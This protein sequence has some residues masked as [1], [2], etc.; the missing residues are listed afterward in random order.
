MT[1][2]E[3]LDLFRKE[4]DDLSKPYLWSDEEFYYYLNEAQNLHVRL[5]GGIADRR[6]PMTKLTYK[7]GDQFKKYDERILRIKGAFDESNKIMTVMNLDNF[8]SVYLEDDYGQ[9]RNVGLEDDRTGNIE[10]LITDVEAEEMQFYP[11]PDHDGWIRLYVYRLPLEVVTASSELEIPSFHHMN[12]LNWVKHKA[13][14]K[15]DVETFNMSKASEFRA[16]FSTWIVEAKKEKASREDRKRVVSY[17]GIP[18]R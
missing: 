12:L 6:S 9:R 11:I 2:K 1:P 13:Y 16:E 5:I 10:Y 3:L 14:L 8:E 7:T 18:M 15:Q 4:V 17:G